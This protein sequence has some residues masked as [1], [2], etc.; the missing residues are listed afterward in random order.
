MPLTKF[1]Q[2]VGAFQRKIQS[3]KDAQALN[4]TLFDIASAVN[5]TR[6]LE[7]LYERIYA[8]LNRLITLPNFF[9]AIFNPKKGLIEFVYCID[10]KCKYDPI[11]ED[12]GNPRSLT[13]QVIAAQKPLLFDE[14][15]LLERERRKEVIGERPRVWLG[16]PLIV[17][18]DVIGAIAVQ[19]YAD[20]DYFSKKEMDLLTAV[21]DQIAIAIERKQIQEALEKNVRTQRLITEHTSSM[22]AIVNREA[23]YE[24]VNPAHS[25]LGY[26]P[27]DLIGRCSFDFIYP[28][29]V[30]QLM[31]L[32]DKAIKQKVMKAYAKFRFRN[33]NGIF[34][35]I[36]GTFDPINDEEG[37]LE[38]VIFVGEDT[39]TRR[40]TE[41]ALE[42]SEEKFRLIFQTTPDAIVITRLEDGMIVDANEAFLKGLG[43]SREDLVGKFSHEMGV[44]ESPEKRESFISRLKRDG[45]VVNFEMTPTI[46]GR[47]IPALLS[48]QILNLSN[49]PH[50]ITIARD[51]TEYKTLEAELQQRRK[52]ESIGTLAAG[53]AHD[54]NNLL[55]GIM[56]NLDLLAMDKPGFDS[57]HQ[58]NIE[59][60]ITSSKRASKLIKQ[61]QVFAKS[62]GSQKASVDLYKIVK[63]VLDIVSQTTNPMI[64]K[65]S[66]L[67]EN[68][69][70]VN[71]YEDELHQV[72]MNL[73][74]NG[75]QAIEEKNE[76]GDEV[77]EI[78]AAPVTPDDDHFSLLPDDRF[79][80]IRFRDTGPGMDKETR[81]K[82]FDP[83]FSTKQMGD[84]RG[85]GLGLAIVYNII[86]QKHNGYISIETQK[87]HGT[88]F[89]IYLPMAEKKNMTVIPPKDTPGGQETILVI[90]DEKM[91]RNVAVK[92]LKL[93]GY[94]TL[95]AEDGEEGLQLFRD[96]RPSIDLV[97]LDLIMPRMSGTKVFKNILEIDP[98]MKVII[99]SGQISDQDQT[100]LL[101]R[102]HAH[103]SKPYRIQE[104][105]KIVRQVLDI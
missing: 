76:L 40:Q 69:F 64:R 83:M 71:G 52:M 63:D 89:H 32:L 21:S 55:A 37:Q 29:D 28:E 88:I 86:T 58:E 92:S 85:Q 48:S 10:Q 18:Q 67:V 97:L 96:H 47:Q 6:N 41:K 2:K 94:R 38:K 77:I 98:S 14:A 43:I 39:T 74:V 27:K 9:I 16:V 95:E 22:I 51:M 57:E 15:Y 100:D 3:L 65:S 50:I 17:R 35:Y 42:E 36:E 61:L 84:R 75:I 87:G 82:A 79:I 78:T 66:D 53:I 80:H 44:W 93:F 68:H 34:H 101:G 104:L 23:V 26:M 25:T 13:G 105:K 45:E 12:L 49:E 99:A 31:T 102:A 30:N 73:C 59:N 7:E 56:G 91:V 103:I 72:V 20:P 4:H 81:E 1:N 24:Y 19:D 33:K 11:V 60:A 70:F 46:M 62:S 54:F 5:T 8:A 90:E